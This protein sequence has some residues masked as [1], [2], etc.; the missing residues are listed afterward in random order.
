MSE[1]VN[2][3]KRVCKYA[4]CNFKYDALALGCKVHGCADV[5]STCLCMVNFWLVPV[6]MRYTML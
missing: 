5:R 3:P 2:P 4:L 1:S 6:R